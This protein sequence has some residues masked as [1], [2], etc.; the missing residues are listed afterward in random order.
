MSYLTR[1]L[2]PTL[3]RAAREFPAVM[4]TGPRQSG[5]TT[6]LRRLFPGHRYLALDLPD[7]RALAASDPRGFLDAYAGPVIL[8]EVQRAPELLPYLRDAIDRNRARRGRYLLTGSQ[9]ILL[10]ERVSET[11]AGRA[12]VLTLLPLSWSERL[13]V[14]TAPFP[15]ERSKRSARV[16]IMRELW[17]GI[18]R[19]AFPEIALARRRDAALW[20]SSYLQTY[21]ERDVRSL[22]QVGSLTEFDAFLR[23]LAARNAQLLNLSELA[24]QLGIAVN[25]AKAWLSVLEAT[26]QILVLRP[27]HSNLGKRLVKS[28]RVYFVDTGTVASLTGLEDPRHAARGPLGGALWETTV[29]VDTWKR[30]LHRGQR[31]A[32]YFWRTATGQEVDLVIEL[33]D[34]LIAVEAKQSSTPRP[35]MASGIAAF[36]D[37]YG[38]RLKHGYVIHPGTVATELGEGVQA[39]PFARWALGG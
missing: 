38:D 2:E 37:L 10:S 9:N 28:P 25:T 30:F 15:W 16:P 18:I 4:L 19:G 6:T 13:G 20:H 14:P 33:G 27:Y 3:L 5:K 7:I 31:P 36:R 22:R 21:L 29:I 26:H 32:L 24:R 23:L 11:L 17:A 35:K 1:A 34:R 8:D 12:A 39:V